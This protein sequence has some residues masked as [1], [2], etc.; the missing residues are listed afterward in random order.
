MA[1]T[2]N[3]V[4]PTTSRYTN[5]AQTGTPLP[6]V[7]GDMT[8]NSTFGAWVAPCINQAAFVYCFAGWAV[9]SSQT[10][11]VF[12]D[13]IA[14]TNFSFNAT[15]NYESQGIIAT[16]TFDA[17]VTGN[18]TVKGKGK[19]N[20][21]GA[22]ITNPIDILS[23]LY[24]Y[25]AAQN[26]KLPGKKNS[27]WSVAQNAAAIQAYTGA[28]IIIADNSY[29]FWLTKILSEFI[30]EW[31]TS[32]EGF[33]FIRLDTSIFKPADAAGFLWQRAYASS[34]IMRRNYAN[35][36][37]QVTANYAVTLTDIDKRYKIDAQAGF[38]KLD[39]GAATASLPSQRKYGVKFLYRNYEWVR[40][41]ATVTA[42]QTRLVEIYAQPIR[43]FEVTEQGVHNIHVEQ[44]DYIGFSWERLKDKNGLPLRNQICRVV[45]KS[46]NMDALSIAWELIDTGAFV[47]EPAFWDGVHTAGD[48]GT[49]GGGRSQTV[50]P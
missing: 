13:N 23:D 21:A 37:N 30:G 42:L 18:V 17:A 35:I 16:L 20:S 48:G 50:Y 47:T 26:I 8:E 15:H 6:L 12:I 24:A 25:A 28:G 40:N 34:P 14:V 7:Y 22:L 2:D 38:Y 39:T 11:S 4:L 32:G 10:P 9:L 46:I 31:W 27:A 41:T 1:I 19:L 3:I 5:P 45:S 44:G 43:L 33:L 36:Y 29:A 49:F